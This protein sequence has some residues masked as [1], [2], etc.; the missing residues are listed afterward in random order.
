MLDLRGAIRATFCGTADLL[1]QD[2]ELM[3]LSRWNESV[4]RYH[5]SRFLAAAHRD[6]DQFV[7]CGKIDLVL[8]T[9]SEMAFVEFKFYNRPRRYDPY[10]GAV[11]GFKGAPSPKN[12]GEFVSCV[13][14][15]H[16]RVG[17]DALSKFIVLFYAD[18]NDGS[19]HKHTYAKQYLE[20]RHPN[21]RVT[22]RVLTSIAPMESQE[23]TVNAHL[24]EVT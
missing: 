24:F 1:R 4:L 21:S 6:V 15:L 12:L 23:G 17:G 19:A 3:P 20:Y 16:R 22:L 10:T 2:L 11:T 7:E 8:R 13:D 14:T 18:P 9:T 5:F